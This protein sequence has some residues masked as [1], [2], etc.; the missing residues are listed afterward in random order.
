MILMQTTSVDSNL[1]CWNDASGA[2]RRS[3]A[4]ADVIPATTSG[5]EADCGGDPVEST[6]ATS[7]GMYLPRRRDPGHVVTAMPVLADD[8]PNLVC[9]WGGIDH[10]SDPYG[11]GLPYRDH[12]SQFGAQMAGG[13]CPSGASEARPTPPI[14]SAREEKAAHKEM[15]QRNEGNA[16]RYRYPAI[17]T[18]EKDRHFMREEEKL[19]G[20]QSNNAEDHAL[21]S[22][23]ACSHTAH[24]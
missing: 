9:P 18:S 24:T 5:A 22:S 3:V 13:G 8:D 19:P 1:G 12:I 20:A 17:W 7:T 2:R 23:L 11:F 14:A 4:I 10:Q 16:E 15:M 6:Q 21:A